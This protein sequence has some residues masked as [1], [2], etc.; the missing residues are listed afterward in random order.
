[1]DSQLPKLKR[2]T[3]NMQNRKKILLLSDDMLS[4]SGIAT[5]SKAF[6]F[7]TADKFN[8][9][10]IAAAVQHPNE[11]QIIDISELV[12]KETGISDPSVKLYPVSG[13]G[14]KQLLRQIIEMEK[15]DAIMH[16]TDP[17]YWDWLYHMEYEIHHEFKIPIVYYSIWDNLPTPY[18]NNSAYMSCD[19]LIAINKQTHFIHKDVLDSENVKY[20]DLLNSNTNPNLE[21]DEVLLNFVPHGIDETKYYPITEEHSEWNEFNEFKRQFKE[22][23]GVN[24]V[25]FWNN[26]NIRRKQGNDV[27][28]AFVKFVELLK[29]KQ[30][31]AFK[32]DVALLMHTDPISEHGADLFATKKA[33]ADDCKIIFSNKK[34]S[35]EHLNFFYNLSD[36]TINIASNEGFGLS[37]AESLMAGTP[38]INNVTGGL[39]DQL[40]FYKVTDTEVISWLKD[41]KTPTNHKGTFSVNN[42]GAWAFPIFPSNISLQG[43]IPTPYIYDDRVNPDDVA[44]TML[45]I[46]DKYDSSELNSIGISGRNW[47]ID[48]AGMNL[49]SMADGIYNSIVTLL[50]NW[51]GRT[52]IT[53]ENI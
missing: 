15:S 43:S 53:V 37:S 50:N 17:R 34:L 25:F 38:V 30:G 36:A 24:R 29:E 13:Y 52:R 42:Y 12:T 41:D 20:K 46:Y 5:M 3:D 35:Q 14:N 6:V 28:L 2:V 26:R 48:E 1:M 32:N 51:K 47:L 45:T 23:H 7:K 33:L 11:G 39:Q 22:N 49:S 31:K 16:F 10:Q 27:I 4:T 9:V 18:Y 40:G 19:L 44:K 21:V 8:W